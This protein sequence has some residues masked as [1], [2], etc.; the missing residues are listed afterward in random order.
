MFYHYLKGP[1]ERNSQK[2]ISGCQEWKKK[3]IGSDCY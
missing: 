1:E 2:Q 3:G